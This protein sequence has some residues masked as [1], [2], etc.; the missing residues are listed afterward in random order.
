MI[1]LLV[2][3]IYILI[4]KDKVVIIG[5]NLKSNVLAQQV[6]S[7]QRDIGT[8]ED[9]SFIRDDEYKELF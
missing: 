1:I 3:S 9:H 4:H 7:Y 5:F 8:W 2:L 6:G